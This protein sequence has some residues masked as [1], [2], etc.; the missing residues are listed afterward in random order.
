MRCHGILAHRPER[1]QPDK[2]GNFETMGK[3]GMGG[4]EQ[5]IPSGSGGILAVNRRLDA[6]PEALL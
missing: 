6:P 3:S 4:P 5:S 2:V 1:L